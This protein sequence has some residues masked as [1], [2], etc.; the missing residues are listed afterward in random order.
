MRARTETP[1]WCTLS[2]RRQPGNRPDVLR[3]EFDAIGHALAPAGVIAASAGAGLEQAAGDV[4]IMDAAGIL[5]LK[6]DEAAPAAP[7][8]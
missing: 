4:G 7:V 3:R 2:G 1:A 6:L 8:A 5:V